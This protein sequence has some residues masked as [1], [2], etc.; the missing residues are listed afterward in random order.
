MGNSTLSN[1][2]TSGSLLNT[3]I[4]SE[5]TGN[6]YLKLH[7][8]DTADGINGDMVFQLFND[9]AP[10]TVA[11]ITGLVNESPSFY[12]NLHLPSHPSEFS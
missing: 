7:V 1:S 9:L 11:K 4:S 5:N 3:A 2:T 6:T 10:N 8:Q 12:N